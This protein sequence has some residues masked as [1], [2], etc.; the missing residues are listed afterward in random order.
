LPREEEKDEAT[1]ASELEAAAPFLV[2]E[3]EEPA[4]PF[5]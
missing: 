2:E 4:G 3:E 5:F 1:G